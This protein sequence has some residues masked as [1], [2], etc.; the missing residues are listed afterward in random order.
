MD[1]AYE[2]MKWEKPTME[3]QSSET[4]KTPVVLIDFLMGNAFTES[5]EKFQKHKKLS[6][7]VIWTSTLLSAIYTIP[8]E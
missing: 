6:K 7:A 5:F 3:R 1:V 2:W 4:E 8:C